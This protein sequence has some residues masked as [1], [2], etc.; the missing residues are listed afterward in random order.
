MS[1]P[2]YPW[3]WGS[4]YWPLLSSFSSSSAIYYVAFSF[5]SSLC[6]YPIS[7][8]FDLSE[9]C[10]CLMFDTCQC[11]GLEDTW[12]WPRRSLQSDI[13]TP[14]LPSC[15]PSPSLNMWIP[16]HRRRRLAVSLQIVPPPLQQ[17][18]GICNVSLFFVS[19]PR[20]APRPAGGETDV[21][22]DII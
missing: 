15:Q 1:I 19:K 9:C 2:S 13:I 12:A 22:V 10:V 11:W 17:W 6:L 14:L 3:Y 21:R 4:W 8:I 20:P 16:C 5:N 18:A 7:Y